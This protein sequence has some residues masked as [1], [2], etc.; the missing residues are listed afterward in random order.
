MAQEYVVRHALVVAAVNVGWVIAL[1]QGGVATPIKVPTGATRITKYAVDLT[2]TAAQ[3]A[4]SGIAVSIRVSGNGVDGPE[5][6]LPGGGIRCDTLTIGGSTIVMP[7]FIP[8]DIPVR[9]GNGITLTGYYQGVDVNTPEVQ[10][11]LCFE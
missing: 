5:A 10:V 6:I 8:V 9:S 3:V 4:S 7:E 11:T 1:S 2:N